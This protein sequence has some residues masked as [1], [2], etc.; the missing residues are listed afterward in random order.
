[1]QHIENQ[2]QQSP[3]PAKGHHVGWHIDK[4]LWTRQ[5]SQTGD[6]WTRVLKAALRLICLPIHP[7]GIT[8]SDF[9]SMNK[10]GGVIVPKM[11]RNAKEDMGL[12]TYCTEP[13]SMKL[14]QREQV[15]K[16]HANR[17]AEQSCVIRN[18]RKVMSWTIGLCVMGLCQY[19]LMGRLGCLP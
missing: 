19:N 15:K 8:N 9:D 7:F 5:H 1:M 11:N 6:L 10:S 17:F 2:L 4:L 12:S 13:P 14:K 16:W 18:R 3:V